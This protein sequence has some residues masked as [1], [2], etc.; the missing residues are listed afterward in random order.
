M[1]NVTLDIEK[2]QEKVAQCVKADCPAAGECIR[3]MVRRGCSPS[4]EYVKMVNPDAIQMKEGRCQF[5]RDTTLSLFG[6]GFERYFDLLSY[7]EAQRAKAV[8]LAYFGSRM[9]VWRYRTGKF[10]ISPE[11]KADIDRIL[12][13]VGVATP[14]QCD[15]YETDFR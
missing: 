1:D 8:L 2:L 14:L 9:Q 12:L 3:Q 11:M 13:Q 4:L 7:K 15:S 6:V 10:R 5:F